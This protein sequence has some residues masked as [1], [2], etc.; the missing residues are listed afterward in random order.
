LV[1]SNEPVQYIKGIIVHILLAYIAASPGDINIL[2][3]FRILK[4]LRFLKAL[5]IIIELNSN[6]GAF[7][8]F[9]DPG[10]SIIPRGTLDTTHAT[11]VKMFSDSALVR[12]MPLP[13][14]NLKW[15]F[16]YK[17]FYS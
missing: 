11:M 8:A 9:D 6:K 17:L 10:M 15:F 13:L 12:A 1:L 7:N 3:T 14:R 2:K 5:S 16:G 4:T